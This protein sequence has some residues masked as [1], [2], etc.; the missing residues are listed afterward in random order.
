VW[1]RGA[2][3][4]AEPEACR[5]ARIRK[6]EARPGSLGHQAETRYSLLGGNQLDHEAHHDATAGK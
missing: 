6:D 3:R 5:V 4:P 2:Q 1:S